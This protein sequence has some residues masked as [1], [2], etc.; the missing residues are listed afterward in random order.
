MSTTRLNTFHDDIKGTSHGG[1]FV[2]EREIAEL[3]INLKS[4]LPVWPAHDNNVMIL[5]LDPIVA[6]GGGPPAFEFDKVGPALGAVAQ[7]AFGG[8]GLGVAGK[9]TGANAAD[10]DGVMPIGV[11]EVVNKAN[12]LLAAK[13]ANVVVAERTP[14]VIVKVRGAKPAPADLGATR[15]ALEKP[16]HRKEER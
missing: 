1:V 4:E 12:L 11:F 14:F 10:G 16:N 6:L 5:I 7:A 2:R 15:S 13:L 9:I 8:I 3:A